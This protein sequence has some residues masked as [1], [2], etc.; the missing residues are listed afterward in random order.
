MAVSNVSNDF[1]N[2]QAML[3]EVNIS[4]SVLEERFIKECLT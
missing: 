3:G 2:C 1:E 4:L